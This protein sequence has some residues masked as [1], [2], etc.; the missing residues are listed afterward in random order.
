[1]RITA[2]NKKILTQEVKLNQTSS[3]QVNAGDVF[4]AKII[5]IH[6]EAILLKLSDGSSLRAQVSNPERFVEGETMDFTVSENVSKSNLPLIEIANLQDNT[7]MNNE[8]KLKLDAVGIK[9][10]DEN[11]EAFKV[12]KDLGL[13]VTKENVLELTK[14]F[15][16]LSKIS[17]SFA[18]VSSEILGDSNKELSSKQAIPDRQNASVKQTIVNDSNIKGNIEADDILSKFASKIGVKDVD[19]LKNLS[20]KEVVIKILDNVPKSNNSIV[21]NA[22]KEENAQKEVSEKEALS[23]ENKPKEAIKSLKS[24]INTVLGVSTDEETGKTPVLKENIDKL[25]LLLKTNK[26]FSIKNLSMLSKLSFEETNMSEQVKSLGVKLEKFPELKELQ[27]LLK[28]FNVEDF[29]TE[30]RVKEYFDKLVAELSSVNTEV[31]TEDV[32]SDIKT[33]ID[34]VTF[35]EQDM[36][37]VSW[38]QIPLNL[39]SKQG[40][41]DIFIK[42]DNSNGKKYDRENVKI[43]IALNTEYLNLFQAVIDIKNNVLNIDLKLED[44]HVKEVVDQNIGVLRESLEIEQFDDVNIQSSVRGK[45]QF[46]EF[47]SDAVNLGHINIKV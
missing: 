16:Y 47:V 24:I 13:E 21:E 5:A 22:P 46:S 42:D 38:V 31:L 7:T 11:I 41:L 8:I 1:M 2:Q 39:N 28:G 12:L 35:L 6:T 26:S 36:N 43:L 34:S 9:P 37:D 32:K 44:E 25:G 4:K 17:D 45:I 20:L 18:K 3:K 30:N 10:S 40:N 14:N 15:K 29:K 23:T 33:L 19:V 27:V